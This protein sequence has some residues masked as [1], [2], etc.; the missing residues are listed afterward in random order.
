VQSCK[1]DVD[2]VA[3][4]RLETIA[5]QLKLRLEAFKGLILQQYD[6]RIEPL[7]AAIKAIGGQASLSDFVEKTNKAD[8]VLEDLAGGEALL[9][10]DGDGAKFA[11]SYF[12]LEDA[13]KAKCALCTKIGEEPPQELEAL[14]EGGRTFAILNAAQTLTRS[15]EGSL[16]SRA[17]LVQLLVEQAL[18]P[19]QVE[20][21]PPGVYNL[22]RMEYSLLKQQNSR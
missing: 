4:T 17:D 5:K 12:A 18:S 1:A 3:F 20:S 16:R 6:A 21:L 15:L 8:V 10:E 14:A 9:V 19:K 11:T 7:A 22:L 2:N 13:F